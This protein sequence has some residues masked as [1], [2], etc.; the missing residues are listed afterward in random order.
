[1]AEDK[2]R[3]TLNFVQ[4]DDGAYDVNISSQG[5]GGDLGLVAL[6]LDLALASILEAPQEPSDSSSASD[7]VEG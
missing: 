7:G 4:D 2:K 6:F 1:M 5:L 3:I